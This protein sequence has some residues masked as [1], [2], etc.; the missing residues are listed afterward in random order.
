MILIPGR[1][2]IHALPSTLVLQDGDVFCSNRQLSGA[3]KLQWWLRNQQ[4]WIKT[5][6]KLSQVVGMRYIKAKKFKQQRNV[7]SQQWKIA[8]TR[9]G[10]VGELEKV[11]LAKKMRHARWSQNL[12]DSRNFGANLFNGSL[13]PK[14]KWSQLNYQPY[15]D[16]PKTGKL[17]SG[18]DKHL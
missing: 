4:Q 12:C 14:L 3:T 1:V 8:V 15:K 17:Y 16:G 7:K 5:Y 10:Q 11:L 9:F 13:L 6:Q 2:G 18:G